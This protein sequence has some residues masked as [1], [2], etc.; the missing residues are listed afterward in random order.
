MFA[1]KNIFGY[2]CH[3]FIFQLCTFSLKICVYLIGL[4]KEPSLHFLHH[5]EDVRMGFSI[6]MFIYQTFLFFSQRTIQIEQ[7]Y[8]WIACLLDLLRFIGCIADAANGSY[9]NVQLI[10]RK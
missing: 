4:C 1:F 7:D 5:K 10:G 6:R 2:Q 9:L 8:K 3:F